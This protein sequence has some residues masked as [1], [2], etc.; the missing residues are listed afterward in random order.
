MSNNLAR[1]EG[2]LEKLVGFDTTSHRT[3][4]PLIIYIES[5]LKQADI[6]FQRVMNESGDKCSLFA[7]I[8][9]DVAGG[10]GLSGHTDVVPV[11][12]QVWTSDPFTLTKRGERL[13]GRGTTDMK[14]FVA[15]TL[16]SLDLFKRADLLR[17]IHLL[18]SYDEEVGCTGVRPM[19]SELGGRLAKP[20]MI[21]VGEPTKCEVVDAHKSILSFVTKITG[22]EAHSSLLHKGVSAIVPA[23][24]LIAKL[25]DIQTELASTQNNSRFDPPYSTIH[26]GHVSGGTARNIIAQNCEFLW[27]VRALP[28][29]DGRNIL[30]QMTDYAQSELV[31]AMKEISQGTG[32]ETIDC[33]IV[34]GFAAKSEVINIALKLANR[35]ETF[36]VSYGT[37]AG[38]FDEADIPSV[39]CGPGDIHQAHKPDEFIERA[40]LHKCMRML[41]RVVAQQQV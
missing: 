27:E 12:G 23:A 25:D 30:I 5:L 7:T 6:P 38:L 18:F 17:P 8:G 9:P 35:N 14:G 37:E 20:S 16:A 10:I 41:E 24:R 28:G 31:P 2:I 22:L 3:N 39:V 34:P 11:D 21:L 13:Y 19:I 4:L 32:I 40:E 36:A 26:V 33:G 15:C 29:F 1:A